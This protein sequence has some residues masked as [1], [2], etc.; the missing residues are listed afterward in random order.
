MKFGILLSLFLVFTSVRVLAESDMEAAA[1]AAISDDATALVAAPPAEKAKSEDEI[2]VNFAKL[3]KAEAAESSN[4]RLFLTFGLMAIILGVGYYL[5][6]K[7]GRPANTQ[8]TKIKI[9]TQHYLGPKR[10][11]AIV[12]VAGE[13]ILIGITEQNINMIKSLSLLDDEIPEAVTT[14]SFQETFAEKKE[15]TTDNSS[16]GFTLNKETTKDTGNEEFSIRHIKDV[17]SLKLKGMRSDV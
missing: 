8:Q 15:M 14:S 7:Y 11:L 9:L 1:K 3:K 17:V 16:V 5:A 4:G 2:P 13:S 10:S 6:K 12:R